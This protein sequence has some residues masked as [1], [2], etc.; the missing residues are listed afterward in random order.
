VAKSSWIPTAAFV[1]VVLL[2][3]WNIYQ[4]LTVCSLGIPGLTIQFSGCSKVTA[5]SAR[6]DGVWKYKLESD[7]GWTATGTI[8]L[9]SNNG[10]VSGTMDNPDPHRPGEKSP[11]EGKYLNESLILDRQTNQEG[12]TQ[13]YT[14]FWSGPRLAGSF[15]NIGN[16]KNLYRDSGKLELYR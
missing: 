9:L 15:K 2:V 7:S 14:L 8:D 10:V 1:I 12:I 11:V 16:L 4:G 13:E 5:P 3:L 6:I